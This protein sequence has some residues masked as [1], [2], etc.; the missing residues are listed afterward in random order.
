MKKITSILTAT[1]LIW[2]LLSIPVEAGQS[3]VKGAIRSVDLNR[4]LVTIAKRGGE[5]VT[6]N[7]T[8]R[9]EITRN[10]QP[11]RLHDLQAG[12][13]ATAKYDSRSLAA[14]R[15]DARGEER[16]PLS[17]VDGTFSGVDAQSSTVVISPLGE[18]EPVRLT[19][20]S[21]TELMLD[22]R[23][24]SL[25]E[26]ASGFGVVALMREGSTEA[27][28]VSAES[29]AEVRGVIRAVNAEAKTVTI[30][31]LSGESLVTLN[32]TEG[33]LIGLNGR[34]AGL[35]DL[36]AG[37]HARASFEPDSHNARRIDAASLLEI[38]G[39]IRAVNVERA[40]VTIA[41]LSDS[42]A[43]ELQVV[44]STV[45]TINGEAAPLD[46]LQPGMSAKAIYNLASLVA[47]KIDARTEGSSDC[48]AVAT[49]GEIKGV[50]VEAKTLTIDPEGEGEEVTLNITE[51]TE[52]T[53]NGRPARLN[54]LL[55]GMKVGARFC[56][57][58]LNA[59]AVA[60]RDREEECT[61]VGVEGAIARVHLET[62]TLVIATASGELV[63]LNV[64]P[65]TEIKLNGEEAR[66]ADLQPGMRVGA[67][68]CRETLVALS[69]AA[70]S[71]EDCT[72]V[73]VSG[74]IERVD[75]EGHHLVI[76]PQGEGES[77]TL[78]ITERT[79]IALDGRPARLADLQPGMKVSA[80]F[81]RETLNALAVIATSEDECHAEGVQ[82]EISRIDTDAKMIAI[83]PPGSSE[84]VVLNVVE[85]TEITLDGHPARLGDLQVGMRA[86]ARFCRDTKT[87]L[88][89]A[90]LSGG[91]DCTLAS[92]EGVIARVNVDEGKL[93][94]AT[95]SGEQV[96]LNITNRTEIILDGRPAR[97]HEL[98]QGMKAA[99]R[100]C[101]ETQEA[102]SV[103]ASS[104]AGDCTAA[105]V[106]G[107]IARVSLE[108]SKLVIAVASGE[109]VTLN[110]TDRTEI[111]VNDQAARL[112]DLRPGMRA[113]ARFCRE[114]LNALAVAAT[115]STADCTVVRV[116]GAIARVN[117][118]GHTVTIAVA[119]GEQV[120]LNITDRTEIKINGQAARLE[121]LSAG[122]KVEARF[123]RET[124][125]A[126]AIQATR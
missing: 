92:V 51:R 32:V 42:P 110:V 125:N 85:R 99:A 18:G 15:I 5:P 44:H 23:S 27:V 66:L 40:T 4:G 21:A 31:P 98:Q 71:Q 78:N 68:V 9:T 91:G 95:P 74:E 83:T 61:V 1:L 93:A 126:L 8:D 114:T 30:D 38:L 54:E 48:T 22:G 115:T 122:M 16:A 94:I 19:I 103:V 25:E 53:L 123:C 97:L 3:R 81:C 86:A 73:G 7:V 67:R 118:E 62:S 105:S 84:A 106:E 89:I 2:G 113:A 37:Y 82:G 75:V 111:K 100:F 108:E 33:T 77:L 49:A 112:S 46:R 14:S 29:L 20:T 121:D 90:A 11:A 96:T 60:A 10:G 45:I 107:E 72:A 117:L 102:L 120:T 55:P 24:A 50:D 41:P 63:T 69:I 109:Q 28:T 12:D 13:K 124:L 6:V 101:R 47:E 80:R 116:E 52:I 104:G 64:T 36:A 35:A 88:A 76:D 65:R 79:E 34:P 17:R 43:V 59:L 119:S 87:A 56:R 70:T 58:T 26:M 39:H 57:E